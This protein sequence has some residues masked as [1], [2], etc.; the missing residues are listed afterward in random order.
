L[1]DLPGYFVPVLPPREEIKIGEQVVVL[2][3]EE[4]VL[5]RHWYTL[6]YFDGFIDPILQLQIVHVCELL[7]RREF[8]LRPP[9]HHSGEESV[10]SGPE[11]PVENLVTFSTNYVSTGV[12]HGMVLKQRVETMVSIGSVHSNQR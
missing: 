2:D 7:F 4:V 12:D 9:L 3:L 1:D 8:S 11:R 5:V 6:E 10:I